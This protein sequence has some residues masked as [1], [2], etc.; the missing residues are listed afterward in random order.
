MTSIDGSSRLA[1]VRDVTGV[2][3]GKCTCS[4]NGCNDGHHC[5]ISRDGCEK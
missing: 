5:G 1:A 2:T 3:R 4:C